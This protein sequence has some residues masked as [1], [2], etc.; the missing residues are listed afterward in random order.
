MFVSDLFCLSNRFL[1]YNLVSRNLKLRYRLSVI[2]VLWSLLLPICNAL[3]YYFVFL[4]FLKIKIP[5]Y[6]LFIV[7]GTVLWSFVSQS[8]MDGMDSLN[9][10]LGLITKVPLPLQV[11]PLACAATAFVHLLIAFTVVF[12]ILIFSPLALSPTLL[13]LPVLLGALF[14]IC[15]SFALLLSALVVYTNDLRQIITVFL[16]IWFY[17]T[18]VVYSENMIPEKYHWLLYAN[19]FGTLFASFHDVIVYQ[20]WPTELYSLMVTGWCI[21][22][23]SAGYIVFRHQ[24]NRIPEVI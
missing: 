1:V 3:V 17:A 9:S 20:T 12:V 23:V 18:P 4:V 5:N 16:Q 15:Y 13:L 8:L 2:G 7:S 6:L 21:L 11:F 24:R 22:S 19:P 10:N 14:L